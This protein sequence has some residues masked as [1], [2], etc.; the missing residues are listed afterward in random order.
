MIAV[1]AERRSIF[2]EYSGRRTPPAARLRP[3]TG[4]PRSC[5]MSEAGR[6]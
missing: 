1:R 5:R 4:F 2:L 3:C 6:G